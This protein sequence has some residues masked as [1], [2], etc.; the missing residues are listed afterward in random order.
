MMTGLNI[1]KK[2]SVMFVV[3]SIIVLLLAV[4]W[5]VQNYG[6]VNYDDN[7]YVTDNHLIQ[8]GITFQSLIHSFLYIQTGNWHPLTMLSHALDWQLYGYRSGGHHWTSVI[9]HIVNTI[10]LFLLFKA[11]TGT[12]WRSA[13]VAALFALHPINVESV[14]WVAE[15]KNV[16]STFFWIL[17]MLFYVWY[18]KQP[19]WRRYLPV[20]ISFALGLMSKPMLVTLPFALLL[21]DYWPLQRTQI[22]TQPEYQQTD[23][24]GLSLKKIRLFDLVLEKVPLFILA[25]IS[26]YLTLS[27][28]KA[29][30]AIVD[31]QSFPFLYRLGN[32]VISYAVYIRKMF[33]PVDLA[34]FYPF[35]Y[36]MSL[37]Q[38]ISS[39]LL[40]ITVTFFASVYFRRFPYLLIGWLWYLG[41]LVPVIGIVQVGSQAMADRYAYI[42]FIGLFIMLSWGIFDILNKKVSV[43]LN[44]IIAIL[45][46]IGL[47]VITHRQVQYWENTLTLFSHAV[48]VTKNNAVAHSNVAGELLVQNKVDEAM[49]H[50]E[51]ALLLSP[52]DYN[53]LVRVARGYSVCG[54]SV[55][56]INALRKAIQIHP[57]Y[58]RAYDD[59]YVILIQVGKVK[60]ALQEYRK[61]VNANKG[62][63]DLYIK[64]GNVLAG[65]GYYDEAIVQYKKAL[66]LRP[67]DIDACNNIGVILMALG[68]NDESIGY[69]KEVIKI[70]PNHAHAH[71]RLSIILK[72]KGMTKEAEY[73]ALMARRIN[74]AYKN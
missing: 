67:R 37:W 58:I 49:V 27:A 44:I 2:H 43:T 32:A 73:H 69:F 10:L 17:A 30:K 5:P 39:F 8:S 9:I 11:M 21:L 15:R 7:L 25:A 45:I 62:N 29:V 56:A 72:Q 63:P 48:A 36:S 38:V 40:I 12:L 18:V 35:N 31:I 22:N 64:F 23:A 57:E 54:E 70:N 33:W 14:A 60:E 16:L 46:I 20:L 68:N 65:Q 1:L 59:L 52:N 4:Y 34:V 13:L 50:C 6:F 66:K 47:T 53:T 26:S 51:K 19:S 61:A 41:T 74:S 71:Y 55:K 42:P 28:Q 24:R 3:L